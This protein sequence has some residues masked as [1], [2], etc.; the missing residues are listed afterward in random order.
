MNSPNVNCQGN[1]Y[2]ANCRWFYTGN[3]SS[4]R[5]SR[6]PILRSWPTRSNARS[7]GT[8]SSRVLSAGCDSRPTRTATAPGT[9]WT[10]TRP[11]CRPAVVEAST[12]RWA[13]R[14]VSHSTR[15]SRRSS[16]STAQARARRALSIATRRIPA[17]EPTSSRG[18][19]TDA[20]PWHTPHPSSWPAPIL[21]ARELDLQSA[22]VASRRGSS[23]SVAP[24]PMHQDAYH[25]YAQP[26]PNA[27]W[28]SASSEASTPPCP[29]GSATFQPGR[30]YWDQDN[31]PLNN[32]EFGY[33][34]DNPHMRPNSIRTIQ[35]RHH[36]PNDH[37]RIHRVLDRTLIRSPDSSRYTSRDTV[38]SRAMGISSATTR[39]GEHAATGGGL[40]VQRSVMRLRRLGPL[41]E[42][43]TMSAQTRRQ[44]GSSVIRA[45]TT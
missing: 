10:W 8:A 19:S 26:V 5:T 12:W 39:A 9:P 7:R 13:S 3:G 22:D 25:R 35:D 28:M 14:A 34:D 1:S 2:N 11:A 38:R 16:S 30:N 18:C 29:P 44:A 40:R 4:R 21:P 24:A 31:N 23:E 27:R 20:T 33:K 36:L 6:R 37:E 15:T 17:R 32:R 45:A 41:P 42:I 43:H